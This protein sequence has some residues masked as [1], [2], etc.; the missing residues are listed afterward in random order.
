G[1][2]ESGGVE[3]FAERFVAEGSGVCGVG[4]CEEALDSGDG[5]GAWEAFWFFACGDSGH[6]VVFADVVDDEEAGEGV[7]GGDFARDGCGGGAVF[8]EAGDPCEDVVLEDV[9]GVAHASLECEEE[10]LLEVVAVGERGVGGESAFVEEVVD[11]LFDVCCDGR[12]VFVFG[13]GGCF[14]C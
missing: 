13:G 4:L 12:H 7:E 11:E 5:E 10:E 2:A 8:F 9:F 6:E 3:E 1:D 14:S